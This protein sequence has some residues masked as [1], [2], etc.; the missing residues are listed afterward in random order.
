MNSTSFVIATKEGKIICFDFSM[1]RIQNYDN[2]DS[3]IVWLEKLD[4]REMNS[5]LVASADGA[6]SVW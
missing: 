6:I 1:K 5:F 2:T 3:P 4:S